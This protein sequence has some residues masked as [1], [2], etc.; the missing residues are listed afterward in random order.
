MRS[1]IIIVK[2]WWYL[3]IL[4]LSKFFRNHNKK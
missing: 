1:F 3:K 4:F 2:Y